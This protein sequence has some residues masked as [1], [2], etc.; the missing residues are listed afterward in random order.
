MHSPFFRNWEDRDHYPDIVSWQTPHLY[1]RLTWCLPAHSLL[2]SL[3]HDQPL[4]PLA[5]ALGQRREALAWSKNG[6]VLTS[7]TYFCFSLWKSRQEDIYP[8]KLTFMIEFSVTTTLLEFVLGLSKADKEEEHKCCHCI[9]LCSSPC[10]NLWALDQA[11]FLLLFSQTTTTTMHFS[12]L[13]S[14]ISLLWGANGNRAIQNMMDEPE[15]M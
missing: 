4:A 12:K 8:L 5:R 2:P 3:L 14:T 9:H 15:E 10:Y 13:V 1:G 11:F 6:L 7:F